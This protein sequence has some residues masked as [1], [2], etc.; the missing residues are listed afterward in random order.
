MRTNIFEAECLPL[1]FSEEQLTAFNFTANVNG[2]D[3]DNSEFESDPS[4]GEIAKITKYAFFPR[5]I[6]THESTVFKIPQMNG[7]ETFCLEGIRDKNLE[8]RY[9]VESKN[10]KGL[11]FEKVFEFKSSELKFVY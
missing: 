11:E 10:L 5:R 9:A 8:F 4:S 2:L 7:V 3:E 6:V 1:D